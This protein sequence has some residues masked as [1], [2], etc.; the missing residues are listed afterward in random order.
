MPLDPELNF[1]WPMP[2]LSDVADL[3]L[4]FRRFAD[5]LADDLTTSGSLSY[6]PSWQS[7]P[8]TVYGGGTSN[9]PG[10]SVTKQGVYSMEKSSG[11]LIVTAVIGFNTGV[12]GAYGQL[13]IG[14]PAPAISSLRGQL[15]PN[16]LYIPATNTVWNGLSFVDPGASYCR[17]HFPIS[18]T[19]AAEHFPWSSNSGLYTN[20]T[21]PIWDP[22][23]PQNS[24]IQPGGWICVSGQYRVS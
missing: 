13:T 11:M 3:P 15:M 24:C 16:M 23:N 5:T 2:A 1:D 8:G 12:Y 4:A 18:N 22:S 7:I 10:G 21:I 9:Q 17:P 19:R 14:L 20:S 6:T